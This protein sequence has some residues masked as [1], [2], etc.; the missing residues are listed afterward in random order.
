MALVESH[1]SLERHPKT[2]KLMRLTGWDLDVTLGKI[3]RLWWWC[4]KYAKDGNLAAFENSLIASAMGVPE[5]QA[6]SVIEALI[7]AEFLN[8]QDGFWVTNWQRYRLR[9]RDVTLKRERQR[10][11]VR[12]RVRKHRVTKSVT[13]RR[14]HRRETGNAD[15]TLPNPKSNAASNAANEGVPQKKL[16]T[17]KTLKPLLQETS[18]TI[19]DLKN[20]GAAKI[21]PIPAVLSD[22]K[23]YRDDRRLC[24]KIPEVWDSWA[25]AFPAI[26]LQAEIFKAHVW[27]LANSTKTNRVRFLTNWFSRAQDRP[28]REHDNAVRQSPVSYA[29]IARAKRASE[30]LRTV[31]A[32]GSVLDS[33]R[34][35]PNVQNPSDRGD[36]VRHG[37]ARGAVEGVREESSLEAT[38]DRGE[39]A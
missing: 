34:S 36:G 6:N 1:S 16:K 25:K 27:E 2:L 13:Q 10:L 4:S 26:D 20:G 30:G 14:S 32:P 19:G 11:Q 3:H 28:R 29:T 24:A 18:Y 5:D 33:W 38:E 7:S 37:D 39:T 17:L 12:Y 8:R 15:V 21:V 31:A 23:L 22:L 9:Y 35:L